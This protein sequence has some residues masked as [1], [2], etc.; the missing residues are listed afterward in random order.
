M[1][2]HPKFG[3]GVITL[4]STSLEMPR[5]EVIACME[6]PWGLLQ[7]MKGEWPD[8]RL[9]R[10]RTE[11]EERLLAALEVIQFADKFGHKDPRVVK[12]TLKQLMID[13]SEESTGTRHE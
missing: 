11:I 4:L 3:E 6:K 7:A 10:Q 9:D 8:Y 12:E 2:R 1:K 13:R 5:D